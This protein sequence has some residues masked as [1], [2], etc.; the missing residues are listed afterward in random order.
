VLLSSP[1]PKSLGEQLEEK[2]KDLLSKLG[3]GKKEREFDFCQQLQ[4]DGWPKIYKDS[5]AVIYQKTL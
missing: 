1:K 4:K 5:V 3:V 2:L